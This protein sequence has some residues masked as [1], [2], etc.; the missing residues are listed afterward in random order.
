MNLPCNGRALK[1][2]GAHSPGQSEA[3]PR[4]SNI[5][6][7]RALQGQKHKN[8]WKVRIVSI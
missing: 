4:E 2:Q 1:G 8:V 5:D 3:A 6:N 7:S